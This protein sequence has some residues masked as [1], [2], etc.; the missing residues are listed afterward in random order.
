MERS[1]I[2]VHCIGY[3]QSNDSRPVLINGSHLDERHSLDVTNRATQLNN[4]HFGCFIAIGH[5]NLCH[6]G[7]LKTQKIVTSLISKVE[8][9]AFNNY[10]DEKMWVGGRVVREKL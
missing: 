5:G 7:N 2:C 1:K 3:C 6:S 9:G 4:A 10:V 8:K